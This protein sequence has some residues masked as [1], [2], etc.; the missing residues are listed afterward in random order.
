M[1]L[2]SA[3]YKYLDVRAENGDELDVLCPVHE[4]RN[5]SCRVNTKKGLYYCHTCHAAGKL[6]TLLKEMA[7]GHIT[8]SNEIDI[9]E[10]DL[11][12]LNGSSHHHPERWL[13]QFDGD[14]RYWIEKRGL[15]PSTV[16]RFRLGFDAANRQPTYPI[17]DLQGRVLGVVRRQLGRF[18]QTRYLYPDGVRVHDH[19]FGAFEAVS[20]YGSCSTVYL[21]EGAVDAMAMWEAGVVGLGIYGSRISEQQVS[22]LRKLGANVVVLAFDDDAAGDKAVWGWRA[23]TKDGREGKFIPGAVHML[24]GFIVERIDW[25]MIRGPERP[26]SKSRQL[27]P[28]SISR[29]QRRELIEDTVGVL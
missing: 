28:A 26:R 22:I 10:L 13:D 6:E 21:T 5:P 3:A 19:L 27:D 14:D 24:K 7:G 9:H 12:S 25:E 23:P 4:D 20:E 29:R 15:K 11:S 2:R 18:V 1:D 8:I 17:R 16:R